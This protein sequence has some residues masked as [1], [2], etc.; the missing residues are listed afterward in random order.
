MY[1]RSLWLLKI[2]QDS[3]SGMGDVLTG[4]VPLNLSLVDPIYA[5]PDEGS[6]NGYGPEG[7]SPQRVW[8]KASVMIKKTHHGQRQAEKALMIFVFCGSAVL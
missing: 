8:V 4:D 5:R 6:T 2:F 1:D 7:V 3:Q